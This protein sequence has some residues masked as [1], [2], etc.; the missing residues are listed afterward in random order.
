MTQKNEV[1]LYA[2]LE[3]PKELEDSEEV[4]RELSCIVILDTALED[5]QYYYEFLTGEQD[6]TPEEAEQWIENHYEDMS[7]ISNKIWKLVDKELKKFLR[8]KKF[9]IF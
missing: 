6:F 5:T 3:K 9:F 4:K 2:I 1:I 7:K 8:K